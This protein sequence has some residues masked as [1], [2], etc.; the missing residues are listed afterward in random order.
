MK[1]YISHPHAQHIHNGNVPRL[2]VTQSHV[3]IPLYNLIRKSIE[4]MAQ[5]SPF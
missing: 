3:N 4:N 2:T 5:H 1:V